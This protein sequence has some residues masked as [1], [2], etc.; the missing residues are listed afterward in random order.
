MQHATVSALLN[1]MRYRAPVE[2]EQKISEWVGRFCAMDWLS[3]E[4][5]KPG[6]PAKAWQVAPGLRDH[7]TVRRKQVQAARAEM[8]AILKAG[9]SRKAS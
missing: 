4:E 5:S 1:T 6:V 2:P 8:H 7:F 9:G 3:P